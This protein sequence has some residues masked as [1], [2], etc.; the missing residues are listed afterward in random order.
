[1]PTFSPTIYGTKRHW[2]AESEGD[3]PSPEKRVGIEVAS[4]FGE[5]MPPDAAK[6]SSSQSILDDI[7]DLGMGA[8]TL[9]SGS[10]GVDLSR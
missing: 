2:T 7:L 4:L 9:H 1:M 10:D 3:G 8:P 5:L 6:K